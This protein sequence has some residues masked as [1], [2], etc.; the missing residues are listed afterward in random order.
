MT[1]DIV[2][3]VEYRLKQAD[4]TLIAAKELSANGHTTG[5]PSIARIMLCFIVA[6]GCWPPKGWAAVNIAEY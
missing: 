4:E 6:W 3:L 5:M 2:K 1:G